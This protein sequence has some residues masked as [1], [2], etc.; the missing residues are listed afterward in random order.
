MAYDKIIPVTSRLDHCVDYIKNPEKTDLSA[1][2]EY[3]TNE[4]KTIG[5]LVDGINCDAETAY[6]EMNATKQRWSKCGG[7]LGYHL[8]HSYAPCEV[9]PEQAHAIGLNLPAVCWA[10]AMK[11]SSQPTLTVN[12][13]TAIS[14]SIPSALWMGAN[15]ATHS[16]T[17]SAIFAISP[18]RSA[19]RTA[20]PSFSRANMA[21]TMPNGTPSRPVRQRFVIWCGGIL[22]APSHRRS[23]SKPFGRS[24]NAWAIL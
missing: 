11:P 6:A 5:V 16:R 7:V 12:I 3:I 18:M 23:R 9:T 2:L 13:C 4:G 8:I 1:E 15:T 14:C 20:Y 24:W 17:T 10:N 19:Q 22:T 21:N